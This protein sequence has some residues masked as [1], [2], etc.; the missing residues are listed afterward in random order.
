MK[1]NG[2]FVIGSPKAA[3][4]AAAKGARAGAAPKAPAMKTTTARTPTKSIG[5]GGKKVASGVKLGNH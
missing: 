5:F 2:K 4:A 1:A 3:A